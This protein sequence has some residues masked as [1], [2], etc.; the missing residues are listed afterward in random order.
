MSDFSLLQSSL[1][2]RPKSRSMGVKLIVVCGLA[3]FMAIPAFFVEGL[4]DERTSRA[5]DVTREISGHVGGRQTFLGPTL[6]IPYSIAPRT[7]AESTT[8]GIYLVFPS[9]AS[10]D[11]KTTT[12]ERRRSLFKVPVF[13]ADLK[14][15]AAFDLTGVPAAAPFG[16]VLDWSRAEIVVGV[17]DARGALADAT[18][19]IGGKTLTLV[20]AQI[21]ENIAMGGDQDQHNKL[22]LFGAKAGDIARPDA[23]FKASSSLRFSGAERIA[24]LAYGKTTHLTEHGD[25]PGPGFDGG[26]LPFSRTVSNQGFAAE[27]TVPFIAR[28][29][30]AEGSAGLITGLDAT[31]LGVSFIEVADPYQSVNRSL[32]YVLLFLGMVFLA[33]FIFEVTTGKRVHPAQYILVGVAQIIFYLL[34]L[35]LAERIG[36]D[37]GFLLAGTATVILFSLN[38][39][40]IF[41]SRLQGIR[42]LVVFSLLY[43]SIYL[44]LRLED[45]ALLMGAI[46]SFLIVAAVM[47]F[48]RGIDWYS[49]LP[50]PDTTGQ[51]PPPA[52]GSTGTSTSS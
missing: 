47:Y 1:P 11:I 9:Q 27:W 41:S 36:F 12:E 48:T 7:P 10:A 46:A 28:G 21:A 25:W 35:S 4:I 50:A 31:A 23:Q 49:S 43:G 13:Q 40:W 8:Y 6:A 44:L 24:L 22:T 16:A 18:L 45:N 29:V 3:L 17:S 20:P 42:A 37:Y 39:A 30:R 38:A 14:L 33:Y 26:V 5:A 52:P 32:K 15:D 34:L 2:V 19:T 51:E